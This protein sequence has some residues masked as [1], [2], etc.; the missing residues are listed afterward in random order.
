M[1]GNKGKSGSSKWKKTNNSTNATAENED[2]AMTHDAQQ[3][4]TREHQSTEREQTAALAMNSH[5][6]EKKKKKSS[7]KSRTSPRKLGKGKSPKKG[8]CGAS[9]NV[10]FIEE[11]DRVQM[12]V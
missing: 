6:K 12:E 7:N 9:A 8:S 11:N 2:V 10:T 4:S 1:A 3:L 5:S